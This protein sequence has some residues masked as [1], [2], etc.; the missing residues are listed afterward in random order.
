MKLIFTDNDGA[1]HEWPLDISKLLVTELEAIERVTQLGYL[2]FA[3]ALDKFSVGAYRALIWVLLKRKSPTLKYS[4][5]DFSIS[6]LQLE[7]DED[8]LEAA[9]A[10]LSEGED[11]SPKEAKRPA[12][13]RAAKV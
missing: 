6:Q 13:K 10:A 3:E 7:P 2:Q 8:E 4:A 5:F 12:R 9:K 1:Q 11:A